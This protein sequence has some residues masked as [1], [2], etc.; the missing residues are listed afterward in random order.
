[1]HIPISLLLL[2]LCLAGCAADLHRAPGPGEPDVIPITEELLAAQGGHAAQPAAGAGGAAVS[3]SAVGL[4]AGGPQDDAL[5]AGP[6]VGPYRLGAGDVLAI[7]VWD[8]PE[9]TGAVA[10]DQGGDGGAL[11][12]PAASFVIDQDGMLEFPFAGKLHLAGRTREQA[13]S[14]LVARL[15]RYFRA[16]RVTVSVQAYRSQRVYLDGEVKA[17]GLLAINDIPMTLL[18]AINRAGG[19]LP[20]ADQSRITI[21]RGGQ[22]HRVDL[23]AALRGG[24][25]PAALLLADGDIVRV[26]P[27]DESK[28]FIGGEVLTPRA[29]TMHDG[30]LTLNEALGEAGG[31]SPQSGDA[32]QVYVVRHTPQGARVYRLDARPARALALAEQFELWPRDVVY[33]AASPLANWHRAISQLFPGELSSVVGATRP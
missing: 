30:R 4:Q 6:A 32:G 10:R 8:H 13:R 31:I 19:M 28:V 7:T 26:P 24:R 27:R 15:A 14:L 17:P 18:E 20:G 16:P 33:V 1:M 5:P 12:P 23:A 2:P 21:E 29:L 3:P 22:R 11:G 25:H 9:L